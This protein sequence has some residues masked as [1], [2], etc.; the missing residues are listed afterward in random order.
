MCKR[1]II[2]NVELEKQ[3][4]QKRIRF[5]KRNENLVEEVRVFLKKKRFSAS[6]NKN[7]IFCF[8]PDQSRQG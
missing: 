2:E 4:I 3:E 1:K 6:R 7:I 8:N 5:K